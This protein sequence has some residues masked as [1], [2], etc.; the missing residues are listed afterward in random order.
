M[1][2]GDTARAL[3][4]APLNHA[5]AAGQPDEPPNTQLKDALELA[6]VKA[7]L[8]QQAETLKDV[9]LP[10]TLK[11]FKL[12]GK[13]KDYPGDDDPTVITRKVAFAILQLRNSTFTINANVYRA[14]HT[15][16]KDEKG[17]VRVATRMTMPNSGKMGGFKPIL[18]TDDPREERALTEFRK[19]VAD[20]FKVWLSKLAN[21]NAVV[22]AKG[23]SHADEVV[24]F[25]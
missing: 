8:E 21:G 19:H 18:D 22:T 10:F 12:N 1:A 13:A 6:A 2:K 7:A 23:S 5:P 9:V 15:T 14:T 25:E 16:V 4:N 20:E 3:A 11:G 24:D 17:R